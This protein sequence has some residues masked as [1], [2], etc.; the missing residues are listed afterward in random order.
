MVSAKL[1]YN[2]IGTEQAQK[3]ATILTEH[4]TLKSLCGNQ[5]DNPILDMSDQEL[6]A[7]GAIM[8]APEI[9]ANGALTKLKIGRNLLGGYRD[10]HYHWTSDLTGI[11]AL[12]AA[13]PECK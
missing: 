2:R 3:L 10:V 8:L 1:L 13:I 11:N 12:A 9:V 7:D 6:C 4:A 5:G